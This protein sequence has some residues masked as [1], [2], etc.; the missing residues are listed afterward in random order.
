VFL[1]FSVIHK[2]CS[3]HIHEYNHAPLRWL[4]GS[5]L[6]MAISL[7]ILKP[8]DK[9]I[10]SQPPERCISFL[11]PGRLVLAPQTEDS[12]CETNTRTPSMQKPRVDGS[13][14]RWIDGL[15]DPWIHGSMG[16][17]IGRSMGRW[18]HGSALSKVAFT[19]SSSTGQIV[20]PH[21]MYQKPSFRCGAD[22]LRS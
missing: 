20:L 10:T 1:F 19:N 3:L 12:E 15:M 7:Q 9:S 21:S 14:G 6:P 22:Q 16:R 18:I 17:W 2:V 13:M 11:K 4:P 8:I 5:Q